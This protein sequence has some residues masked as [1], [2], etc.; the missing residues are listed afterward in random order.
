MFDFSL[1]NNLVKKH[2]D[3]SVLELKFNYVTDRIYSMTIIFNRNSLY[4][5]EYKVSINGYEKLIIYNHHLCHFHCET[6]KLKQEKQ[7][8]EELLLIIK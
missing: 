5:C 1:I 3:G 7:F 2:L 8:E 4:R 6:I